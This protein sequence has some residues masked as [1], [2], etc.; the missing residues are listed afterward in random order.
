AP[1]RPA[2]APAVAGRAHRH[3]ARPLA[4]KAGLGGAAGGPPLRGARPRRRGAAAR[5]LD[6]GAGSGE[7]AARHRA[8]RG[9]AAAGARPRARFRFRPTEGVPPEGVTHMRVTV[10]WKIFFGSI[11]LALSIVILNVVYT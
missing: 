3:P 9:P 1:A 2:T 10:K 6:G 4:R 8:R 7:P 11:V 5:A